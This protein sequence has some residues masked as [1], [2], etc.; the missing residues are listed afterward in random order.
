MN[1][2]NF[3]NQEKEY[4][5]EVVLICYHIKPCVLFYVTEEMFACCRKLRQLY[6]GHFHKYVRAFQT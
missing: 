1:K 3:H 2:Y 5:A 6:L 4:Y